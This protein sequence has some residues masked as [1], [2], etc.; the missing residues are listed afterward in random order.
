ML[1]LEGVFW[2]PKDVISTL[3]FV[4]YQSH[5]NH[6]HQT[7]WNRK[8]QEATCSCQFWG[9]QG[10][11]ENEAKNLFNEST[12]VCIACPITIQCCRDMC[13]PGCMA[14]HSKW[15]LAWFQNCCNVG[16]EMACGSTPILQTTSDVAQ[17]SGMSHFGWCHQH[18]AHCPYQVLDELGGDAKKIT[19]KEPRQSDDAQNRYRSY[20]WWHHSILAQIHLD[21]DVTLMSWFCSPNLMLLPIF[22][23]RVIPRGTLLVLWTYANFDP[24]NKS[25]YRGEKTP[26][27]GVK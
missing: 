16:V 21:L 8:N 19:E 12:W 9:P 20:T 22:P 26:L 4:T 24:R 14:P 10:E 25:T 5:P 6:D 27:T 18:L 7:F 13:A 15:S 17:S 11:I 2:W 3:G 1:F 23:F